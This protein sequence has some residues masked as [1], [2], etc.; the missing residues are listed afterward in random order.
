M[1]RDRVPVSHLQFA[2][3][4]LFFSSGNDQK[5]LNLKIILQIFELVSGLKVNM[6][7]C[8]VVGINCDGVKI[9]RLA[10]FLGCSVGEWPLAYLGLP[11]GGNPYAESFW[12]PVVERVRKRLDGWKRALISKGGRLVLVQ[13][14]L[15]SIPTYYLSLFRVPLRWHMH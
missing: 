7:K 10:D 13:S 9:Q 1:G 5:F 4:T 2:D 15:S 8:S 3:D 14:V 6:G 11:L 12:S